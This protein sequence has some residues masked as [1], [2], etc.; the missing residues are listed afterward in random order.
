MVG[1]E[2][3]TLEVCL[4]TAQKKEHRRSGG[5]HKK[6][7]EEKEEVSKAKSVFLGLCQEKR[8]IRTLVLVLQTALAECESGFWRKTSGK[9]HCT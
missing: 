1:F 8:P 2:R 5:G 7:A 3:F 6:L 9:R 4:K